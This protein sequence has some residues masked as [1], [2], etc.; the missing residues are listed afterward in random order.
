MIITETRTI[1][2]KD[3]R[4]TYSDDGHIL[5]CGRLQ[6]VNAADPIDSN[7]YYFEEGVVIE[8]NDIDK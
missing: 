7:K 3:F 8:E 6:Y 2:G 4:Y 1:N 5:R